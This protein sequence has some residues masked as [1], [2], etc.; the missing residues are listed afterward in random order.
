MVLTGAICIIRQYETIG[1][2]VSI[3]H[4]LRNDRID[5]FVCCFVVEHIVV[6]FQSM[7]SI[8]NINYSHVSHE[9][10]DIDENEKK[11]R[12][13]SYEIFNAK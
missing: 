3:A 2:H 12:G 10:I 5:D 7:K 11:K 13:N 6:S 1:L 8:S 4:H 9:I